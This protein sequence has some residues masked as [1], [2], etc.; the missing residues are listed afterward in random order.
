MSLNGKA[1]IAGAYEHPLRKADGLS[2]LRLHADVAKA[3]AGGSF[4]L[5]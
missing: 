3:R 2:V 1:A 4:D 5:A